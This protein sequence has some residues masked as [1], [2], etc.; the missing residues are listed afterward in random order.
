MSSIINI[1]I[2]FNINQWRNSKSKGPIL[3]SIDSP[4]REVLLMNNHSL[5]PIKLTG[6]LC[7]PA[8]SKINPI[9]K[10]FS[11][12]WKQNC[13]PSKMIFK[14]WSKEK[15]TS[16]WKTT[17]HS[18]PSTLIGLS[19]IAHPESSRRLKMCLRKDLGMEKTKRSNSTESLICKKIYH[20]HRRCS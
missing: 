4:K 5:F 14:N 10:F 12:I 18:N 8:T 16:N 11:K 9:A 1:F 7:L 13:Q 2:N 3:T 19:P 15:S 6:D 17:N 20:V